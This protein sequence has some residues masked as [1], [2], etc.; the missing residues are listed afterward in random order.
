M[1]PTSS[2]YGAIPN[3]VH[4]VDEDGN[5]AEHPTEEEKSTLRKVA[6]KIPSIAYWICAVEFAER[7]SYYGVKGLFTNFVNKK[8]PKGGN[9]FGAPKKGTQDTA[10][11]LGLGSEKATAVSQSFSMLVYA[12][13]VLF[14]W[15]ADTKTGRF[16]LVFWGVVVCGIAHVLMVA[17]GAKSLLQSGQAIAPFMISVYVLAIGAGMSLIVAVTRRGSK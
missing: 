17:S 6:G 4:L 13:P 12:L 11:A 9:G 8:L 16:R 7:A 10:G 14:G 15:L 2:E 5:E 3:S 1:D